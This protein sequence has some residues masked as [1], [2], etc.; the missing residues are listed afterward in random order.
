MT[1]YFLHPFIVEC[2]DSA[3]HPRAM[4]RVNADAKKILV[5]G[6][7]KATVI[8]WLSR[9]HFTDGN[10]GVKFSD[11]TATYPKD[12]SLRFARLPDSGADTC[13]GYDVQLNFDFDDSGHLTFYQ[14]FKSDGPPGCRKWRVLDYPI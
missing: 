4:W 10:P 11:Y 12:Q 14:F 7:D 5:P 2:L 1:F 3:I 8:A 13:G 6:S 9:N